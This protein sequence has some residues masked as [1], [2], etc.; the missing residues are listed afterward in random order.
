MRKEYEE[1][2]DKYKWVIDLSKEVQP[3]NLRKTNQSTNVFIFI[4]IFFTSQI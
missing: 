4:F 2:I 3:Y 1:I